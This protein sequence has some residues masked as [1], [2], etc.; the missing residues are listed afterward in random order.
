VSEQLTFEGMPEIPE[1]EPQAFPKRAVYRGKV[2]RV[3]HYEGNNVFRL[4]DPFDYQLS[5]NAKNFTFIS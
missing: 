1:T 5:V 2:H 3:L 4:L